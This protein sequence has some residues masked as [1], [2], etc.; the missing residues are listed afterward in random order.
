MIYESKLYRKQE[1]SNV[2]AEMDTKVFKCPLTYFFHYPL[3][4]IVAQKYHSWRTCHVYFLLWVQLA[5][6][7]DETIYVDSWLANTSIT[8]L[9][10]HPTCLQRH[11]VSFQGM[12]LNSTCECS[13]LAEYCRMQNGKLLDAFTKILIANEQHHSGAVEEYRLRLGK[14]VMPKSDHFQIYWC[15]LLHSWHKIA[16]YN[17]PISMKY[18]ACPK[19]ARYPKST[20]LV[21]SIFKA[22]AENKH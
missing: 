4:C 18:D 21:E 2:L 11:A 13:S 22:E 6:L 19:P 3:L 16:C 17:I 10:V 15:L 12:N 7:P 8:W 1:Q 5:L 20:G 9:Q 14:I